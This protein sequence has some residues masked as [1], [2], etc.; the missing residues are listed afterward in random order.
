[1]KKQNLDDKETVLFIFIIRSY[2]SAHS[3][4]DTTHLIL[5][6]IGKLAQDCK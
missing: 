2:R 3:T 5:V 4:L 6:I 1:M